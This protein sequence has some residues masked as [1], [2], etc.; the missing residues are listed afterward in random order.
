ML[1]EPAAPPSEG[2]TDVR[3]RVPTDGVVLEAAVCAPVCPRA[4]VV[5]ATAGTS[6]GNPAETL[7]T[8][9]GWPTSRLAARGFALLVIDLL[10]GSERADP[11]RRLDVFLLARRLEATTAT[12]RGLPT[13]GTARIAYLAEGSSAAGALV[14][15]LRNPRVAAI[16]SRNGRPD[17]AEGILHRVTAPTLLMANAKTFHMNA[18][19]RRYFRCPTHLA[20]ADSASQRDG[21]DDEHVVWWLSRHVAE[22]ALF[23]MP[24]NR[25]TAK[26]DPGNGRRPPAGFPWPGAGFETRYVLPG[27][28]L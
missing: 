11:R 16:V 18:A 20:R 10:V 25:D 5:L 26:A 3:L 12:L 28:G 17:L 9:G 8:L 22:S 19:V 24:P 14:A 1:A 6:A 4:T 23:L 15:S 27:A 21:A 7:D 13:I 2:F